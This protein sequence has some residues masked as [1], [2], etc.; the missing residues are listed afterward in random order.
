M[1]IN[2]KKLKRWYK[3]RRVIAKE[4]R[5][6]YKGLKTE[7]R[8]L[9][10]EAY[11]K[12]YEKLM[13]ERA[14]KEARG[15]AKT[16]FVPRRVKLQRAAKGFQKFAKGMEEFGKGAAKYHGISTPRRKKR[17]KKRKRRA[18]VSE[19]GPRGLNIPSIRF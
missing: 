19:F 16:K 18:P 17:K 15:R 12:E 5:T 7:E 3:K 2:H 14:I 6:Y 9:Y 4:R 8:K 13:R 11:R 1:P 10:K